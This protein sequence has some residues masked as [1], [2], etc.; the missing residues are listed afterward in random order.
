V[1][2]HN[3]EIRIVIM[4]ELGYGYVVFPKTNLLSVLHTWYGGRIAFDQL[5]GGVIGG[6][7]TKEELAHLH[8]CSSS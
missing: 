5:Y 8:R 7:I 2:S 6:G 1:Q 4:I 3:F